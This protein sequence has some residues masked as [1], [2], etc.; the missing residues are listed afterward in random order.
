MK[1]RYRAAHP[2]WQVVEG[3]GGDPWVKADAVADGLT[4]AA[5]RVLVV[6]DADCWTD[7]LGEAVA[8]L[9]EGA[10]WV[11]PH[12]TVH[13]LTPE[14]TTAVYAGADPADAHDWDQAPY[15]GW[16][17]GGFFVI[18]RVDYQRA[19]MD[20]RFVGW[21]LED[22]SFALAADELV[23]HHQRLTWPLWHLWHPPQPRMSRRVG[24]PESE[25]LW[26]RYRRSR[27]RPDRMSSLVAE[28]RR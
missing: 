8:L 25:A 13:R 20:R 6:A 19:P 16:A 4:R 24:N 9:D 27:G 28:G 17:G 12:L 1:A 22:A 10:P 23:G 14:S 15:H 3:F 11:I 7:G 21:G 18:R 26:R 2:D 5:G